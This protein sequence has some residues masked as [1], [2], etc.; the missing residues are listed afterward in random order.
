MIST[1]Q[2]VNVENFY[3]NLFRIRPDKTAKN[4]TATDRKNTSKAKKGNKQCS[5]VSTDR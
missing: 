3:L 1:I 5:E 4:I 2:N